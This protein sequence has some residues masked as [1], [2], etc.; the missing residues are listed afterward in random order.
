MFA[1]IMNL[2]VW[3]YLAG[4]FVLAA[5][6]AVAGAYALRQFFWAGRSSGSK[7]P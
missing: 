1:V 3:L 4:G 7:R 6:L 2:N 5:L